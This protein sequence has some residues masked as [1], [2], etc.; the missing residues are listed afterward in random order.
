V[1]AAIVWRLTDHFVEYRRIR[2]EPA[3]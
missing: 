3:R 2:T 1:A